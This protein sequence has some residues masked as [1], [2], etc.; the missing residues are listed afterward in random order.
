MNLSE[1]VLD[2]TE[3]FFKTGSLALVMFKQLDS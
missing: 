1:N 3:F 2:I